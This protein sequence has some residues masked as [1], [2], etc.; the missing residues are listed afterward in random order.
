MYL[1]YGKDVLQLHLN[2]TRSLEV[3]VQCILV[4][5]GGFLEKQTNQY[6]GP[7]F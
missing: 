7:L 6:Y 2:I 5:Y 3:P 1:L 4:P